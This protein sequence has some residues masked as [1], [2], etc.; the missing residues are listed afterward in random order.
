MRKIQVDLARFAW[1]PCLPSVAQPSTAPRGWVS[2]CSRAQARQADDGRP[3]GE[4]SLAGNWDWGGT[5]A[6]HWWLGRI[7][8]GAAVGGEGGDCLWGNPVDECVQLLVD[9][10]MRV[11][12]VVLKKD[13]RGG[14]V[15]GCV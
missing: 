13:G 1:F 3:K 7:F 10:G 4:A 8:C 5:G 15:A 6:Q 11:R 14:G 2:T 12:R 9:W